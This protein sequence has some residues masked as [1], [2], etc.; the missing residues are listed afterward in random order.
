MFPE[1]PNHIDWPTSPPLSTQPEPPTTARTSPYTFAG[2]V[3][4]N[5]R[6]PHRRWIP[7]LALGVAG[8]VVGATATSATQYFAKGSSNVLSS[9]AAATPTVTTPTPSPTTPSASPATVTTP[10][11]LPTTPQ[12]ATTQT[13]LTVGVV[14]INTVLAYQH[15]EAA[16]T[17][18]VLS[19]NGEILTNN[20]VVDGATQIT[21]TV[22]TTGRA[23]AATVVG[24][25][26]SADIA[27]LRLGNASGLAVA[28]LGDSSTVHIG[29]AVIGVGNAGG[30]G[31]PTNAPGSVVDLN[32]TVTATDQN[33][34]N[35]ETL[36]NLI[37]ISSNL[38]P[39][40]SGGPLFDAA[41][42]VIGIDSI[43]NISNGGR[44][45]SRSGAGAGYAIAINDA[46]GV[47][48]QI[49]AGK[50]TDTITIGTPPMIGI[51]A[52]TA[53]PP[54]TGAA[55]TAVGTGTPAAK[56]GLQV[57]DVIT[58]VANTKIGTVN[59]L[60]QA[61]HTHKP[62]DKVAVTWTASGV[63]HTATANLIAGPAN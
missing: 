13:D 37:Q 58:A 45:R 21:V 33:G 57:G 41:G 20:H 25:D 15:A 16:G 48:K 19:A 5:T 10:A 35:A 47:A 36:N 59:D 54:Q 28:A 32:Q 26:P 39:G 56:I 50:A 30:T 24:T 7:A 44:F 22:I 14:N 46:I 4:P 40:E 11:P 49:D 3:S 55:V 62:G 18:I 2:P 9:S 42:K 12:R 51:D 17:G 1:D 8:L 52:T 61:L 38:Q 6:T 60:T 31:T 43:G 23:Y 29:D 63:T 53:L 34:T 27:V